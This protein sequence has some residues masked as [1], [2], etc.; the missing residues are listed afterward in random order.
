[1]R[2]ARRRVPFPCCLTL[3]AC[4]PRLPRV[5]GER[6]VGRSRRRRAGLG[7]E[8]RGQPRGGEPASAF[9]TGARVP[10]H[11]VG[12][13]ATE[14]LLW[15][16]LWR[17]LWTQAARIPTASLRFR[18]STAFQCRRKRMFLSDCVCFWRGR[19]GLNAEVFLGSCGTDWRPGNRGRR[20]SPGVTLLG[21]NG[22]HSLTSRLLSEIG[23]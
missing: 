7:S 9:L 8:G 18:T 4:A 14:G 21:F 10:P 3:V 19:R 15:D 17:V 16:G 5:R 1:M 12:A 13:Q 11:V 2:G 23:K 22:P 6:L 20:C